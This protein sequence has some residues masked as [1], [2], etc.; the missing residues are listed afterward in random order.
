MIC[1]ATV[2]KC[3]I[4]FIRWLTVLCLVL[5]GMQVMVTA[6]NNAPVANP[7]VYTTNEDTPLVVSLSSPVVDQQQTAWDTGFP[8]GGYQTFTAGQTGE[9]TSINLVQNGGESENPQ[10]VTLTVYAGDGINGVRLGEVIIS[11]TNTPDSTWNEWVQTY[12][13][14]KP[15]AIVSGSVYTFM[16]VSSSG[17]GLVGS[18]NSET[19]AYTNGRFYGFGGHTGDLSFRTSVATSEGLLVNDSD[20]EGNSLTA[21]IVTNPSN[22]SVVLNSDGKFTYTPNA[23]FNGTDTFSYQANDGTVNSVAATVTVN[24]AAVNDVP[25]LAAIAVSSTEDTTLAF[26]AANFIGAYADPENTAPA[27]I[28]VATLPA[29]GLLKLG[30]GNVT[31]SQVIPAANLAS[32]TYVPGANENGAKTFT[33]TASDGTLSS[34]AATVTM[35]RA[36]VNDAP[37]LAAMAATGK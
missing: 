30:T 26:T 4:A 6:T 36:A 33:V 21:V 3:S 31:A 10:Q 9:L 2:R 34:A 22:G 29:T 11:E 27:S 8:Y 23:N 14:S 13:F 20:A 37:P 16:I 28:T 18:S 32:L 15:I 25:T 7:D 35:T 24:I 1:Q 17:R 5:N 12:T 19:D